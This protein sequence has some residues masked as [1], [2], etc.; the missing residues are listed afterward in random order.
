[1]ERYRGTVNAPQFPTG[2]EWINTDRPL[3]MRDLRGKVVLLEFWT[4]PKRLQV[5][6]RV[7]HLLSRHN[8]MQQG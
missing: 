2:L 5:F 1:M 7:Q 6:C 4:F 8:C 3:S